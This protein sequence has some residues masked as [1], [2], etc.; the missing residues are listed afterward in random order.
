MLIEEG[1]EGIGGKGRKCIEVLIMWT[2]LTLPQT[3]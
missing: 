2:H 3:E 1:G